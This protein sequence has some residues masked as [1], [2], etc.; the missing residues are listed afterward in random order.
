M[1]KLFLSI[2]SIALIVSC[3][4]NENTAQNNPDFGGAAAKGI[5]EGLR[6]LQTEFEK[7]IIYKYANEDDKEN[8][9][10]EIIKDIYDIEL[11]SSEKE[12][13]SATIEIVEVDIIQNHLDQTLTIK[14]L[15]IEHELSSSENN[16][17]DDD[18]S[19]GK[20]N[21]G[22]K[23]FGTAKDDNSTEKLTKKAAAEFKNQLSSGNC[24]DIRIKR[25][26][27]NARVCARVVKC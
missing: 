17:S 2:A 9:L 15:F 24:L 18:L 14:P 12:N 25:N 27:F 10:T 4:K 8:K 23:N 3:S 13:G 22:W 19:K 6:G 7:G 16:M 26:T 5:S 20:D 21:E 1:K 11:K